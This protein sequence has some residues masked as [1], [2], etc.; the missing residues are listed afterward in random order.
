M[1]EVEKGVEGRWTMATQKWANI[2]SNERFVLTSVMPI[3]LQIPSVPSPEPRV[4]PPQASRSSLRSKSPQPLET[5]VPLKV[6]VARDLPYPNGGNTGSMA[7]H[8]KTQSMTPFQKRAPGARGLV[9]G[10]GSESWGTSRIAS[11]IARWI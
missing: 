7:G 9:D 10:V 4:T 11:R 1:D 2:K 5:F 8:R 3:S 6:V